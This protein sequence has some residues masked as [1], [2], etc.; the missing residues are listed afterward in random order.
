MDPV[1]PRMEIFFMEDGCNHTPGSP[2]GILQ[3]EPLDFATGETTAASEMA[4]GNH[5]QSRIV[6]Q[7]RGSKQESVQPVEHAPMARKKGP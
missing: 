7:D 6:P 1:E 3:P 4:L 5:L 2:T